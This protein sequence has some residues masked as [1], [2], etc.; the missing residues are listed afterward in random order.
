M[1]DNE[2]KRCKPDPAPLPTRVLHVGDQTPSSY[3]RLWETEGA[4]GSYTTLSHCWGNSN[5]LITTRA[6]V[7][8][9][10]KRVDFDKMDKTFQD[11]VTITR[12]LGIQNLWIDSLCIYQDD[13]KD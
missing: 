11:A 7:D 6:T 5:P 10:K 12:I 2:H 9:R 4:I 1:C 13:E 3:I 8:E